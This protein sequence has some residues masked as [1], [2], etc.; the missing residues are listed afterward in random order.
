[1][2]GIV[3]KTGLTSTTSD[4]RW[5][6]SSYSGDTGSCVEVARLTG[7]RVAIRDSKNPTGPVLLFGA[8]AWTHFLADIRQ[9][10]STKE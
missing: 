5:R 2:D 1:V 9:N 8:I 4:V 3:Q 10:P 7:G 6:K